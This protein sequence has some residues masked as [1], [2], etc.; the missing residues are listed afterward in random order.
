M[1][2]PVFSQTN[3]RICESRVNQ[4]KQPHNNKEQRPKPPPRAL[5]RCACLCGALGPPTG[6]HWNNLMSFCVRGCVLEDDEDS[7]TF[8]VFPP[9]PALSLSLSLSSAP[10]N[11]SV[12]A[13]VVQAPQVI[14][15]T[16][17]QSR[18]EPRSWR[19][20]LSVCL[21]AYL[22][23]GSLIDD[24]NS[25][26]NSNSNSSNPKVQPRHHHLPTDDSV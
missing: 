14:V 13:I 4:H 18:I 9:P 1:F 3:K 5:C 10:T 25:N 23:T 8:N 12:L 11:Q 19:V 24:N 6:R 22:S 20:Y 17:E 16:P 2:T 7:R 15:R 21:P 26:S